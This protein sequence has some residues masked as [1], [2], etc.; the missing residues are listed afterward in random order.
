MKNE[1]IKIK[2]IYSQRRKKTVEVKIIDGAF[3]FY[4]PAGISAK[5]EKECI[6]KL[7]SRANKSKH[8]KSQKETDRELKERADRLNN[9]YFKGSLA[10]SSIK[11]VDNQKHR[12]GSCSPLLKT[13]RIS[14]KVAKMPKWVLDYVIVHELAHLIEP[15]HSR[16]FWEIV[17]RYKYAE[18][19]R[20]FLMGCQMEID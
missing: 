4:F 5:Q 2:K 11:Y 3:C 20:G 9:L 12:N 16:R 6:D 14:D 8:K 13:I 18:R 7:I 1:D 17:N 19:A 10:I 15:N